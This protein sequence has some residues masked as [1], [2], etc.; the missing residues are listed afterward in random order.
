MTVSFGTLHMSEHFCVLQA[1][2]NPSR[3]AVGGW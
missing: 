1:F 3:N 2:V